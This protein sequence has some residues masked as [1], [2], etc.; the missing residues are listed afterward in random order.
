MSLILKQISFLSPKQ[1]KIVVILVALYIAKILYKNRAK[2]HASVPMGPEFVPYFGHFFNIQ[3]VMKT[4]VHE[5]ETQVFLNQGKHGPG[6]FATGIP[7]FKPRI[8]IANPKILGTI[9]RDNFLIAERGDMYD[10]LDELFGGGIFSGNSNGEVWKKQRKI[11]SNMFT[12]R[13]LKNYMFGIF[14]DTTYNLINKIN[15]LTS[16]GNAI[17]IYDMFGRLTFEAFTNIAFGVNVNAINVA[18]KHVLFEKYFDRGFEI[19]TMRT[20][21][22]FWKMKKKYF[23]FGVEREMKMITKY[24]HNY[25][26]NIVKDRKKYYKNEIKNMNRNDKRKNKDKFDLLSMFIEDYK[27]NI[28]DEFLRDVTMNFIIAGRDTTSQMLSWFMFHIYNELNVDERNLII[29]NIKKEIVD[30]FGCC[31]KNIKLEYNKVNE[32]KYI[33]ACCKEILRLYPSVPHFSRELIKDFDIKINNKVYNLKK[34]DELFIC[35]YSMGRMPWI[36]DNPNQFNPERFINKTY[37][38]SKWPAFNINP[39]SCLGK[40]VAL[41]EGKVALILFYSY[42]KSFKAVPGQTYQYIPA[43]THQFKQGFKIFVN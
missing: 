28:S 31:D 38:A 15:E 3:K 37:D 16:N 9:W 10:T 2:R 1:R 6:M 22:P 26:D 14:I 25:V 41:L 18:P 36:W 30:V 7:T 32:C 33:E 35:T 23:S 43:A 21:D 39:R 42:F 19:G 13:S 24:L 4:G 34:N 40:N 29:N 5:W 27:G 17:D 20:I 12:M 8:F 11:A